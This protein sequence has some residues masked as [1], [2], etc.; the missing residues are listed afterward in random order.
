[1][2][3]KRFVHTAVV[4]VLALT[5]FLVQDEAEANNFDINTG[6]APFEVVF[7]AVG[8]VFF[9]DVS[10]TGG[11]AS[12]V[13][14]ITTMLTNAWFDAAAPYDLNGNAVGVYSRLN[15][16]S[17][18][19][20]TLANI[21]TAVIYASYHVLNSLLPDRATDWDAMLS[22]AGL[23]PNNNIDPT[24]P[25]GIG[26]L[27]GLGVI[28]GRERDGMNQLGDEDGRTYNLVPYA[29]YTNYKPVNT[30]Y[31][32]RFPSRWQPDLQRQGMGLYKIQQFVTPQ[33]ALTEPY[34]YPDPRV[35][36]FPRP[37]NSKVWRF[38]KYK[39]QADEVLQASA[40]LDDERKMKA[41]FFDNKLDGIGDSAEHVW[42]TRIAQDD[43][44]QS[45]LDFIYL[46]LLT[47]MAAFDAG[48]PV[49]QEKRRYD[50][51]RPYSAIR[52]IYGNQPVTAWGGPGRGTVNDLPANEWKSYLEEADHPEYPS[53]STCFC[54]AHAQAVRSYIPLGSEMPLGDTLNWTVLQEKGSSRIEPGITPDSNI[55]LTFETWTDWANDCGQSR[56]WAGVHF[57]SAVDESA[58]V[59][60]VF[61]DMAHAYLVS[62]L[63][64]TAPER[65][66]SLGLGKEEDY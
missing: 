51:V 64:G 39:Q 33:Y 44:V 54:Y 46:E 20:S 19:E 9:E 43:L 2:K 15:H 60:S 32:L 16:R 12:L 48:I 47:N 42:R 36:S 35:F 17:L 4:P 61:G 52:F 7:P 6:L 59:C 31:K 18:E 28:E 34:T 45:L 49:W 27:A 38:R 23:S 29:D 65:G 66:A 14:R 62:L 1:M 37:I 55:N 50:A 8:P 3:L 30:A 13:L 10:P 53:A 22:N 40:E 63:D 25:D 58:N 21:N 57:Q 5:G 24:T 11:D 26:N 56:I 41:E